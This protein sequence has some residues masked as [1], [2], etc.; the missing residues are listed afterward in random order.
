MPIEDET[1]VIDSAGQWTIGVTQGLARVFIPVMV[2]SIG[3]GLALRI[4]KLGVRIGS[5]E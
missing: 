4:S 1:D 2:F 5:G 3:V